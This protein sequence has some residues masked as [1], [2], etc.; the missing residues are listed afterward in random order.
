MHKNV[1]DFLVLGL[2]SNVS[3][4][5]TKRR[6]TSMNSFVNSHELNSII[7]SEEPTFHHNNKTSESQIDHVYFSPSETLSI[8]LQEHICLKNEPSNFSSHDVLV[9]VITVPVTSSAPK[10]TNS[11]STYTPFQVT[12]IDWSNPEKDGYQEDTAKL[13]DNLIN[14]YS[15]TEFISILCEMFSNSFVMSAINHFGTKTTVNTHT[16]K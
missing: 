8:K 12:R 5:S 9:G 10:M 14:N 7:T 13:L 4:K 15:E 1:N 3:E 2:D 16:K 6:Y 11:L